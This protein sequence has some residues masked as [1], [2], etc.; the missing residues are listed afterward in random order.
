MSNLQSSLVDNME[1]EFVLVDI[2]HP[3][4]Y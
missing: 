3:M 2:E 4:L 1:I